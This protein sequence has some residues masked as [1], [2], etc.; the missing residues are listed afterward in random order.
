[1]EPCISDTLVGHLRNLA[2][3][4]GAAKLVLFGS[5]A[6]G[7]NKERSDIDL[8]VWGL[9]GVSLGR[10]RLALEELPTLLMFDLV[11]ADDCGNAALLESIAREGVTLYDAGEM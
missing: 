5:R 8:A 2:A 3:Q 10:L 7:D 4:S 9:D 1:M 11:C 6:R